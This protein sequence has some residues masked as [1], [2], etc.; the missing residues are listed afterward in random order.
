MLIAPSAPRTEKIHPGTMFRTV[1]R[2]SGGQVRAQGE[3]EEWGGEG[4]VE[5]EKDGDEL[6][7]GCS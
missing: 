7:T 6:L 5:G 4:A 3:K 2:G 1:D